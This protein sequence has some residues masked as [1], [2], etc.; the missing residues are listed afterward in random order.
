MVL[1]QGA[2]SC[3]AHSTAYQPHIQLSMKEGWKDG[4]I[5]GQSNSERD[6][7][8][9]SQRMERCSDREDRGMGSWWEEGVKRYGWKMEG[10]RRGGYPLWVP[11]AASQAVSQW[12]GT[13]AILS[14]S[15][16]YL[17]LS[18]LLFLLQLPSWWTPGLLSLSLFTLSFLPQSASWQA[19]WGHDGRCPLQV[20]QHFLSVPEARSGSIRGRLAL[21]SFSVCEVQLLCS[22]TPLT[23]PI[24]AALGLCK[25]ELT[26]R[27]CLLKICTTAMPQHL[28]TF[29]LC[30]FSLFLFV[31]RSKIEIWDHKQRKNLY[32]DFQTCLKIRISPSV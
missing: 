9:E 28:T 29:Q 25:L 26:T 21:A 15:S 2:G 30:D 22:V 13:E 14:L 11:V 5:I 10:W 1:L 4:G 3:P 31:T 6:Q 23:T 12:M 8:S 24:S 27:P 7:A 18:P 32:K 19:D 16:P 17:F 20:R